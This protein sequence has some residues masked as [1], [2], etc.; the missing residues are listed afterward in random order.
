MDQGCARSMSHS[1]P[2][3]W[4]QECL[5]RVLTVITACIREL[6]RDISKCSQA[7]CRH[8]GFRTSP[9]W[10]VSQVLLSWL[11]FAHGE[12]HFGLLA[13][14][15]WSQFHTHF[16]RTEYAPPQMLHL[17]DFTPSSSWTASSSRSLLATSKC[18]R[19]QSVNTPGAAFAQ[20]AKSRGSTLL[21]PV[22]HWMI[23]GELLFFW[24]TP[25]AWV[26]ATQSGTLSPPPTTVPPS[27][28]P[29]SVSC[30]ISSQ[31]PSSYWDPTSGKP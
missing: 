28:N 31:H 6:R 14:S 8:D 11:S 15:P 26:T 30:Q 9:E 23:A 16:L 5:C 17:P 25:M 22:L 18:I 12:W 2:A 10:A 7:T 20:Q 27:S 29:K 13:S 24:K 19:G 4:V 1:I 3:L 21:P